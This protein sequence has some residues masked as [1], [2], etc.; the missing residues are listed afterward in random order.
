VALKYYL[1]YFHWGSKFNAGYKARE[2]VEEILKRMTLSEIDVFKK[3]ENRRI[4]SPFKLLSLLAES[5]KNKQL[6]HSTVVFQNGTGLDLIIAPV[7][8]KSFRMGRRIVIVHDIESIR[9]GRF[10]DK[11]R[12]KIVFTQFT[13]AICNTKE[14]CNYLREN[15][16][17][18]GNTYTFGF[19]VYLLKY[20]D[21]E[22]INVIPEKEY[23][24]Y[25]IVI[26]G[27]LSKLKAG[28][29]YKISTKL[30]P[31]NYVM[32]LYGKGFTG[33]TV[34]NV[35]EF[36]GAFHPDELPYKLEGHFGLVWDGEEI[37]GI[38][39]K[40]GEYLK[41][42][43]PHKASLYIVSGLPLI[44][45]KE[46]AIYE[47]VKEYNIGFG[48]YS[49]T[50]LDEKLAQITEDEYKT[51]KMNIITLAEKLTTGQNLKEVLKKA[52]DS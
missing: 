49:L 8:E 38:A 48:V 1:P 2:D 33:K 40:T 29:L 28:Y 50:E 52:L 9:H 22:K 11:V 15:L 43:S 51:W 39:G 4:F 37:E 12:E 47:L 44:V 31:K 16:G 21:S 7:L 17:F 35:V 14:M 30:S 36:V 45:W 10:F 23:G 34:P 41:Y 6:K 32:K 13:D 3:K 5:M 42:N 24:R 27:N 46:S 20:V 18:R 26:A 25:R 19:W